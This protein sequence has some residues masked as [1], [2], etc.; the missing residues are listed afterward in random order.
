MID[1][2]HERNDCVV[3][4]MRIRGFGIILA[5]CIFFNIVQIPMQ[6]QAMNV[7]PYY[8]KMYTTS[9]CAVYAAPSLF[10]DVVVYI[11]RFVCVDVT[12]ITENG[13]Y[14]VDLGGVYYIPG[15][16]LVSQ[17]QLPKSPKQ[18][19]LE[20][21]DKLVDAYRIQLE[22][23]ESYSSG[24]ALVDMNGDGVPELFEAGGREI[25]RFN[26]EHAVMIYYNENPT[27]FYV[28]KD[29]KRLAGKYTW[30]N[31]EVWEAY[32]MDYSLFP[33]GQIK[34]F[35]QN[36]SDIKNNLLPVEYNYANDAA[37]RGELYAILKNM[38]SL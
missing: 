18:I 6:T 16:F 27:K 9:G 4:E 8:A 34:C 12:G 21:L 26:G 13:F 14:Q 25:Y 1:L 36:V 11:E 32:F 3:K 37:T 19:A 23:M 15:P 5:V 24:F 38:L 30:I 29:H 22:Q 33:W 35:S 7:I 31:K 28:T 10:T 17:V 2:I 20:N